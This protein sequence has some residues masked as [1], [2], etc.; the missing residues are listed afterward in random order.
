MRI[1]KVSELGKGLGESLRKVLADINDNTPVEEIGFPGHT[2]EDQRENFDWRPDCKERLELAR[3]KV[4]E[5]LQKL[6]QDGN[7]Q[8]ISDA[9]DAI[10]NLCTDIDTEDMN[11]ILE[12]PE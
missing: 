7:S 1:Q 11:K 3:K 6:N 5:L 4:E 12:I 8:R 9:T 2:E 10:I